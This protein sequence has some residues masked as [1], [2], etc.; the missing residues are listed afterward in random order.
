ML[1]VLPILM[2]C[3]YNVAKRGASA[4]FSQLIS[5]LDCYIGHA[6]GFAYGSYDR[7]IRMRRKGIVK[8]V[9]NKHLWSFDHSLCFH[10]ILSLGPNDMYK[11]PATNAQNFGWW[12]Y[13]PSVVGQHW[14]KPY[15]VHSIT[16]SPM[17]RCAFIVLIL[18]ALNKF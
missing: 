7:L 4:N 6:D 11:K 13:D 16:T 2:S 1:I 3:D 12:N 18:L 5:E 17:S 14:H 9:G 15:A 8:P 10:F